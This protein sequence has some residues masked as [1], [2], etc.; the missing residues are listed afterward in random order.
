MLRCELSF[1]NFTRSW[2]YVVN[3]LSRTSH[4]LDA[5]LWTF[6]LELHTLLMLRC[7]LSFW[8]FTRS[9]CYVVNFLSRTSHALRGGFWGGLGGANN[10]L[11]CA[12]Y[13]TP[14]SWCYVVNFPSR[15]SHALDATLWTFFLELHTLL[16]LRCELSF[17]NFTRSWCYVVNFLSRTSH[18][19]DATLWTFF[20]NFTRSWCYVVNFLSGTSHACHQ[21]EKWP[22]QNESRFAF[23]DPAIHVASNNFAM[24][25]PKND[26]MPCRSSEEISWL[27][28][29]ASSTE[30]N[31]LT[32]LQNDQ[33]KRI[34]PHLITKWSRFNQWHGCVKDPKWTGMLW[35]P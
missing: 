27:S 28:M 33:K 25:S 17:W 32:A 20:W 21:K 12:F 10:V 13:L 24:F 29:T 11:S 8:N 9:W 22:S 14:L 19:L 2:C 6:F 15:T 3:F 34:F 26:V 1:W 4:A 30:T 18:A 31:S 35:P 16:V 23:H 7:E 5:T